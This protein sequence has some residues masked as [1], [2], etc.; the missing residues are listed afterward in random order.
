M[1]FE[2]QESQDVGRAV[3]PWA[4]YSTFLI[5][6]FFSCKDN[7]TFLKSCRLLSGS[8]E[9]LC[10]KCLYKIAGL[11]LSLSHTHTRLHSPFC[12]S[13]YPHL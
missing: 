8:N 3:F 2:I 13:P 10:E 12:I 9:I 1:G 7:Y 5:L 4:T 11:P 6:T